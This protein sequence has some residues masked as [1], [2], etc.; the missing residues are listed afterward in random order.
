[1]VTRCLAFAV[2]VIVSIVVLGNMPSV[3][4]QCQDKIPDIISHC[5]QF[6]K[7]EGPK[8][9]P[10]D[11]CCAVLKDADIP[12]LCKYVIT[13]AE[14]IISMDKAIYVA[15]TC[16]CSVPAPGTKCGSKL[17]IYEYDI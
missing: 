5:N 10:S 17:L 2:F 14:A 1:M 15:R 9:L 3:S 6:V 16:G 4:A 13:E 11:D 8:I 7:K 12:C